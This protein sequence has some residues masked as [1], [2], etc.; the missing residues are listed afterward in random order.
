MLGSETNS[1]QRRLRTTPGDLDVDWRKFE[2]GNCSCLRTGRCSRDPKDLPGGGRLLDRVSNC[3]Y[4][5]RSG[6]IRR[7]LPHSRW[8]CMCMYQLYFILSYDRLFR[9]CVI[10][11]PYKNLTKLN[12]K[13]EVKHTTIVTLKLYKVVIKIQAVGLRK[14]Q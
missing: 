3:W 2:V 11:K 7:P 9:N 13:N 5:E 1:E 8:L 6:E 4:R 12:N 14:I 10:Q